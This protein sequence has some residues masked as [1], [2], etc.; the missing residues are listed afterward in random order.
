MTFGLVSEMGWHRRFSLGR[1][2]RR[3]S[4]TT[5]T[6]KASPGW[7]PNAVATLANSPSQLLSA[8]TEERQILSGYSGGPAHEPAPT[9]GRIVGIAVCAREALPQ[10]LLRPREEI[11]QGIGAVCLDGQRPR[12]SALFQRRPRDRPHVGK[13]RSAPQCSGGARSTTFAFPVPRQADANV[14][15]FRCQ[16]LLLRTRRRSS[17]SCW[18]I[19][20]R[21]KRSSRTFI[22]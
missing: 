16:W 20:P 17:Y 10:H 15:D 2:A 4:T 13:A 22:A 12:P 5:G 3:G 11:S 21:A 19:S 9:L 18:S 14:R 1:T 8:P 6:R 7:R